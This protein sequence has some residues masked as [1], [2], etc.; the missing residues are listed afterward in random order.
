VMSVVV[1]YRQPTCA[2]CG[3]V[4]RFLH[5]R[6]VPFTVQDIDAD[7]GALRDFLAF[8]YLTT[9]VT[10]VNGTPVPGFN[11]KRLTALLTPALA[12]DG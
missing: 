1:V 7:P 11:P 9:P 8:G 5:D 12:G 2:A 6:G 3:Q 10:V 4:E